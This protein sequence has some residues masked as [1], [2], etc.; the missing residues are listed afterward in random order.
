MDIVLEFFPQI[1][2]I[3]DFVGQSLQARTE[4]GNDTHVVMR[5]AHDALDPILQ[6]LKK[7]EEFDFVCI[8]VLRGQ[9]MPEGESYQISCTEKTSSKNFT[10]LLSYQKETGCVNISKISLE[11]KP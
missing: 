7:N 11:E 1:N 10:I 2:G 9:R 4:L 6:I 8:E 3:K 5:N